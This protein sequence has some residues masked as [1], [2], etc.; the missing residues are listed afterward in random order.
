[1]PR[2]AGEGVS[3]PG[4]GG[5]GVPEPVP[6]RAPAPERRR[7]G[8]GRAGPAPPESGEEPILHRS[9][10]SADADRLR[11]VWS[12]AWSCPNQRVPPPPGHPPTDSSESSPLTRRGPNP[13]RA[14]NAA[15]RFGRGSPLRARLT[16]SGVAHRFERGSPLRARLTALNVVRTRTRPRPTR[17]LPGG[18][19]LTPHPPRAPAP[20]LAWP[21]PGPGPGLDVRRP[22]PPRPPPPRVAPCS[23]HRPRGEVGAHP[24]PGGRPSHDSG[25]HRDV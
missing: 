9:V 20:A 2:P 21:T 4:P 3:E 10:R 12:T 13:T 15:H 8:R 1:M 17:G 11:W 25:P 7:R 24:A 16:A 5:E 18:P 19:A 23:R 22:A 6:A 14:S